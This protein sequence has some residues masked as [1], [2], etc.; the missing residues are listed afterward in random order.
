MSAKKSKAVTSTI[1]GISGPAHAAVCDS[2]EQ[3]KALWNETLG[4]KSN[5]EAKLQQVCCGMIF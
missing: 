4:V 1:K 3:T 2:C 5:L